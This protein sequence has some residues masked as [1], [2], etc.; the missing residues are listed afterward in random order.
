MIK[1]IKSCLRG[2]AA[3]IFL[4]GTL[5]GSDYIFNN[6]RELDP[7]QYRKSWNSLKKC[8]GGEVDEPRYYSVRGLSNMEGIYLF[9]NI[10]INEKYIPYQYP[11]QHEQ[12]HA[13]GIDGDLVE[14]ILEKCQDPAKLKHLGDD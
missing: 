10:F 13:L 9:G 8:L 1:G 14:K 2:L 6:V 11:V 7:K 12:V 5:I 4:G 3:T